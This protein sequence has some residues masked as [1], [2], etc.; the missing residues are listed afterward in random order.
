MIPYK[1]K[2]FVAD[3]DV[4]KTL[5]PTTKFKLCAPKID[6]TFPNHYYME[7]YLK[8]VILLFRQWKTRYH[9]HTKSYAIWAKWL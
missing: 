5:I 9:M 6:K 1:K 8:P 7:N 2:F 4:K 3:T